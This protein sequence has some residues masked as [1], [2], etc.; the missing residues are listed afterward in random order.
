LPN[1]QEMNP[2]RRRME[3]SVLA[4]ISLFTLIALSILKINNKAIWFAIIL[5][6]TVTINYNYLAK[7][8]ELRVFR[9]SL[10]VFIKY[11]FEPTWYQLN[12]PIGLFIFWIYYFYQ[13]KNRQRR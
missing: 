5:F 11:T 1:G 7:A 6:G 10:F 2:P 3:P 4:I 9:P 13:L 8:T 12:L